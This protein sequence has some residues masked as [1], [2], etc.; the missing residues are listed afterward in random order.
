MSE[1][2][3]VRFAEL[4][5]GYCLDVQPGQSVLVRS[6]TLAEPLLLEL[7]RAILARDAW[8]LLRVELPD[9]AEGWWEAA[10]EVHLD[11]FAP[12]ALAEAEVTDASLRIQAPENTRA[13][14][15]V[16]PEASARAA[17]A[18]RSGSTSASARVFS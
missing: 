13:L 7:Q 18:V 11:G 1:L 2:D 3:P 16:D 15:G 5:A 8:P 6:T 9:Q 4:L 12:A 14:A 17:R 10:R